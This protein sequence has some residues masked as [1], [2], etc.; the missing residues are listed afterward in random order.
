M[1]Q[2]K[3]NGKETLIYWKFKLIDS[4]D[5]K[6]K[7]VETKLSDDFVKWFYFQF[8]GFKTLGIEVC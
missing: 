2:W 8:G 7:Y 4:K 1:I 3:S 5:G 6:K